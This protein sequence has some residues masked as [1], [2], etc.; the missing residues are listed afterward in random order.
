MTRSISD[1]HPAAVAIPAWVRDTDS[2]SARRRRERFARTLAQETGIDY[3]EAAAELERAEQ[4][5]DTLDHVT[6]RECETVA[7]LADVGEQL[8][9]L[10][11]AG[12]ATF[13]R[14]GRLLD[15]LATDVAGEL[16]D[17][18][19]V[20]HTALRRLLINPPTA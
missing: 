16:A 12:V 5:L 13:H 18:N 8:R 7:L 14:S 2:D 15:Q 17:P 11:A 19:T 6:G 4:L 1:D 10:S 20:T 9:G 3:Q